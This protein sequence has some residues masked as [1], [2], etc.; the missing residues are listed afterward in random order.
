MTH[1]DRVGRLTLAGSGLLTLTTFQESEASIELMP[2]KV[3]C[4]PKRARPV[5]IQALMAQ[6]Q[7]HLLSA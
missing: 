4:C 3:Q 6:V 7:H 2:L 5:P 1:S